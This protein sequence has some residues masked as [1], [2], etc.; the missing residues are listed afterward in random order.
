M[1]SEAWPSWPPDEW[2][3]AVRDALRRRPVVRIPEAECGRRAAVALILSAATGKG[4]PN[5][6]FVRRAL[7]QG[8]PWS[9]HVALPGG[10]RDSIDADLLDTAR[11]ETLEETGLR[12]DR[13]DFLGRLREI[14]PRSAHLPSICVTPFVAWLS[15]GQDLRLNQELTGH[16]WVPLPVLTD[17]SHRS[18]LVRQTPGRRTFPAIDYHGD[19]IWGLTF[20]I[21]QDF[22]D[23]LAPTRRASGPHGTR[24]VGP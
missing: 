17:P 20:E 14:H 22:L 24:E 12:L 10:R 15:R 2:P 3:A 21:V 7:V 9:G 16:L 18:T 23:A 6:L 5:A 4:Q 13:E 11:R 8:D 1:S 19:V